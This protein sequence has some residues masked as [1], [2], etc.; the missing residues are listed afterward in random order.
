MRHASCPMCRAPREAGP[1][2]PLHVEA[3]K[4]FFMAIRWPSVIA[5]MR[6]QRILTGVNDA[7]KMMSWF[8]ATDDGAVT[9]AM[10]FEKLKDATPMEDPYYM[11]QLLME[12]ADRD[13]DGKLNIR[14]ITRLIKKPP[15]QTVRRYCA[16]KLF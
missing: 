15:K 11:L 16:M 7:E 9:F 6:K 1:G 12:E 4:E 5:A 14:D 2:D 8:G 13:M 10:L 3:D